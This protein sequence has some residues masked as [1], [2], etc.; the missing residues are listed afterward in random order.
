MLLVPSHYREVIAALA[1]D[2]MVKHGWATPDVHT[3]LSFSLEYSLE[4]MQLERFGVDAI[5]FDPVP[6]LPLQSGAVEEIRAHLAA[7]KRPVEWVWFRACDNSI[8]NGDF[9]QLAAFHAYAFE[10]GD[11][12]NAPTLSGNVA[13]YTPAFT[14]PL[15]VPRHLETRITTLAQ[16]WGR[17]APATLEALLYIALN[18]ERKR[19]GL[20]H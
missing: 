4:E 13:S 18:E 19:R 1:R 10:R 9:F 14:Y 15:A 12:D 16:A 6:L 8:L 2:N 5:F 7:R 17:S 11:N 20:V 3:M